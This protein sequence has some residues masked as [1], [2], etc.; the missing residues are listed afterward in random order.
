MAAVVR[1]K[2]RFDE[3]PLEAL[4]LACKR[5]KTED[6]A[7]TKDE[8]PFTTIL[9]FAGTVNNREDDV[10]SHVSKVLKKDKTKLGLRHKADV[11]G[12]LRTEL[13]KLAQENRLKVVNCFRDLK[14]SDVLESEKETKVSTEDGEKSITIVDVVSHMNDEQE[15]NSLFSKS[16]AKLDLEGDSSG[17]DAGYVYDLYYTSTVGSDALINIET[18]SVHPLAQSDWEYHNPEDSSDMSAEEEEA[19][20]DSND[21]NNWH[22]DYPDSDHSFNEDSI[23]MALRVGDLNLSGEDDLSSD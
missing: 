10:A 17:P 6:L 1:L 12:K 4:V 13:K 2:R 16:Q 23:M 8:N 14:D 11:T 19:E 20:D 3:E 5:K 9:N 15:G 18:L 7:T 22:N 21:E